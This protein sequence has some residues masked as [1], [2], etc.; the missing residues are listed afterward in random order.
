MGRPGRFRDRTRFKSYAGL[1]PR[2]SQAG[3]T[4]RTGQPVRNAGLSLRGESTAPEASSLPPGG[5]NIIRSPHYRGRALGPQRV[6][7]S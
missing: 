6:A 4:Y 1:A 3:D 2:A 7:Q 5:M